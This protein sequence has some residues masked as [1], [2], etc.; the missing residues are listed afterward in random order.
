MTFFLSLLFFLL[1]APAPATATP[2]QAAVDDYRYKLGFLVCDYY[3]NVTSDSGLNATT[4]LQ[5]CIDDAWTDQLVFFL[6]GC[7]T[8]LI[9]DTL[10]LYEWEQ[11]NDSRNAANGSPIQ[12]HALRGT[13]LCGGGARPEIKLVNNAPGFG[14]VAA[15]RPMINLRNFEAQNTNAT[16]NPLPSH[17]LVYCDNP[18]SNPCT[19]PPNFRDRN[20]VASEEMFEGINIHTNGANGNAGAIGIQFD[21]AQSCYLLNSKI[22]ATGSVAGIYG[23]PGRG[24]ITG[25]IEVIGGKYN[26]V[27]GNVGGGMTFADPQGPMMVGLTLSGA[28]QNAIRWKDPVPPIILGFHITKSSAGAAIWSDGAPGVLRDGFIDLTGSPANTI[29]IHNDN[30][31]NFYANDVWVKG[32]TK[33][34][35]TGGPTLHELTGTGPWA[36]IKE[37]A[38]SDQENVDGSSDVNTWPTY[39]STETHFEAR[40]W[41]E[42]GPLSAVALPFTANEMV[43]SNAAAPPNDLQTRHLWATDGKFPSFEDGTGTGDPGCTPPV[44]YR[45]PLC[46]NTAATYIGYQAQNGVTSGAPDRT[47]AIQSA[48]DDADADGHNRVVIPRGTMFISSR[49]LLKPDTH[50][51]GASIMVSIISYHYNWLPTAEVLTGAGSTVLIQSADSAAGTASMSMMQLH[52]RTIPHENAFISHINWR[53]GK[54]SVLFGVLA[55]VP[56][57]GVG[58]P[59]QPIKSLRY[60]QAGGGKLYHWML[61]LSD[62]LDSHSGYRLVQYDS[63]TQ[64]AVWYGANAEITKTGALALCN[65][66]VISNTAGVYLFGMKREGNST[67]VCISNSQEVAIYGIGALK[68]PGGTGHHAVILTGSNNNILVANATPRQRQS[69]PN[70]N[71]IIRNGSTNIVKWPSS[72]SLFE[73]GTL[74]PF[75]WSGGGTLPSDPP[76][77]RSVQVAVA[78]TADICFDSNDSNFP[79]MLPATGATGLTFA[80]DTVPKTPNGAVDRTGIDCFRAPFAG[81]TITTNAQE[82]K[83]SYSPGNITSGATPP[84]AAAIFT[85]RIAENLLPTAPVPV[86]N[87]TRYRFSNFY[88]D[89]TTSTFYGATENEPLLTPV[90]SLFWAWMKVENSTAQAIAEPLYAYVSI[91]GAAAVQLADTCTGNPV[92][93]ADAPALSSGSPIVARRLTQDQSLFV[94]GAFF[95]SFTSPTAIPWP[96]PPSETEYVISLQVCA[97][98]TLG[99]TFRLYLRRPSNVAFASYTDATTPFFTVV[100]ARS[101]VHGSRT[102]GGGKRQ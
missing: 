49:L 78:D 15:P 39:E 61:D 60:S 94:P 48:I 83:V 44:R 56:S 9:S 95:E 75:P 98:A 27:T 36:R 101:R 71:Y 87:M 68:F 31:R 88:G 43:T 81:G 82:M 3:A 6:E 11:W 35:T 32:T 38:W 89:L 84:L 2:P 28:T 91:D 42:G 53:T 86:L 85:D 73:I 96:A 5:T 102:V 24:S 100:S 19:D 97:S 47:A 4:S 14:N 16:G 76:S 37:Y 74:A 26:I 25:N 7:G 63:N 40:S 66:D 21:S 58:L 80:V 99:Q 22:T 30:G 72:V 93:F 45:N 41:R 29:A 90:G 46:Y 50:L 92:A 67:G 1:L 69:A 17:P 13:H 77:V 18:P 79:T 55:R 10:K 57:Q 51:M 20:S 12:S 52:A 54:N 33:L 59:G 65:I 34:V 70:D 23:V 8:Y 64:P 62:T